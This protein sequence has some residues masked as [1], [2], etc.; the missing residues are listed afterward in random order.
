MKPKVPLNLTRIVDLIGDKV[1]AVVKKHPAL[2][3]GGIG[4]GLGAA[5]L[6]T[7]AQQVES[8][9]MRE[10]VGAP[11][12]KY[13]SCP[14]LEKFAAR[15]ISLAAKI[16]FEKT[17][18]TMDFGTEFESGA[19]T[20]AGRSVVMEGINAL[21]RLIGSAAQSISERFIQEP[22]RERIITDITQRDPVISVAEKE[23]PGQAW[24]AYQTMKRFAPTLSTDPNVVT[25][26]LRNTALSGGPM[27]F[28]TIRGLADAETAIQRARNEGAWLRGGF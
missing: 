2:L 13:S 16:S 12:A 14:I 17:A 10:Y 3:A 25:S 8:N 18:D 26:F 27:D 5:N 15:K 24:E 20:Q 4:L 22:R 7:P 9:I 21:R 6:R 19:G 28:Q 1:P 11:G 23:K